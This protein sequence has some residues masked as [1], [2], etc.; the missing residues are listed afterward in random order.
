MITFAVAA[1]AGFVV[2]YFLW[3]FLK[4]DQDR[5]H[6]RHPGKWWGQGKKEDDDHA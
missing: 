4:A 3:G 1:M 5:E 2:G 6:K